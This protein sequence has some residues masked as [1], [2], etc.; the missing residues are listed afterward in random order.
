MNPFDNAWR[1]IKDEAYDKVKNPEH[2][3]HHVPIEFDMEGNPIAPKS[4][5]RNIDIGGK[6]RFGCGGHKV[7]REDLAIGCSNEWCPAN[8]PEA[9]MESSE[10]RPQ[11]RRLLDDRQVDTVGEVFATRPEITRV[12]PNPPED[13]LEGKIARIANRPNMPKQDPHYH[14]AFK[15]DH[16][17]REQD[18]Q[19][20]PPPSYADMRHPDIRTGEEMK[21]LEDAWALMK[22]KKDAPNYRKA[23]DSKTCGNCKA[24]DDSATEDPKTGYCKWYDFN[25]HEDY[26][27]DAW[28]KK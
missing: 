18:T 3:V 27:C 20:N 4:E 24:W 10:G 9:M 7:H 8:T 11:G 14:F 19:G 13:S 21:V 12:D 25:C 1:I 26:T 6:C 16:I 23:T 5:L 17:S 28:A 15:D 2:A 22:A